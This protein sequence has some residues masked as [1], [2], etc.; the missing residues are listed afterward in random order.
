VGSTQRSSKRTASPASDLARSTL[1]GLFGFDSFRH[2]QSQAVEALLEGRDCLAIL[3]T[4]AGKTAIFQVAARALG[5]TTV[6][7]SP[8]VSLME[9]QVARAR[10]RGLRTV[11]VGGA[12]DAGARARQS[13][14]LRTAPP[15][16][17]V[18]AA[19]E[20][21]TSGWGDALARLDVRLM[22]VDEAHCVDRWGREF[23]PD[24]L[25]LGAVRDALGSP[26]CVAVT[27]SA[28]PATAASVSAVLRMRDPVTVRTSC[29]RDNLFLRAQA[30]R[31][32][33]EAS[34]LAVSYASRAQGSGIV[35][36]RSRDGADATA[37][38]CRRRGCDAEAYH[39]RLE[40]TERTQIQE[41]FLSGHTRVVVATVAF[42]MGIDKPDVRWVVHRGLPESLDAYY[43]EVGRA[44]RDGHPADCLLLWSA[45]DL[46]AHRAMRATLED[47]ARRDL[48]LMESDAMLALASG[49]RCRHARIAAWFGEIV[50]RCGDRCDVCSPASAR[51][52]SNPDRCG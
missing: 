27:A 38:L 42:G 33:R 21:L 4:G 46:R 43:Q 8:L 44:G 15:P 40:R 26:V 48:A 17:L 50:E 28:S 34:M 51:V 2:G 10:S 25:E 23:R 41:R 52:L 37:A 13:A 47:P 18:Y 39:A 49:A 36:T 24:Y 5:G 3:P 1:Q 12:P 29:V 45:E 16:E 22:A 14:L 19:P 32:Q 35:Y 6:V 7:V 20:G 30:V 11:R 9:D 31:D